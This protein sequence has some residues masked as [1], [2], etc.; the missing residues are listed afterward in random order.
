MFIAY[1]FGAIFSSPTKPDAQ[2]ASLQLLTEAKQQLN[3]PLC[4]IGG[5]DSSNAKQV[6][7]AGADMV[8]VI[9]GVFAQSEIKTASQQIS[10]FMP[11]QI[12]AY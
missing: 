7:N 12:K 2:N 8:A 11:K 5:I 10:N 1:A 3:I 6:F 9:N 4:A